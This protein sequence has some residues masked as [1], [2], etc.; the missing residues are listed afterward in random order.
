[1][2]KMTFLA[3][4]ALTG[5]TTLAPA[6]AQ[7]FGN[8]TFRVSNGAAQDH[9]VATGVDAMSSCLQEGSGGAMKLRAFY[10]G[11]LGDDAQATQSVRSGSIDMV[12]AGADAL[13]GI[14][15]A[16]G[17]F[18]LPF[19]FSN[20]DEVDQV[21]T[22]PYANDLAEKMAGHQLVM[23]SIWENGFRH[24]TNSVRPIQSVADFEGLSIRVIQNPIYL[25]TF[26]TL[27]ANP[28][29]MSFGEVFTALETGAVDG[30][31]NPLPLIQ[32]Q[33][34]YEV[35]DYA[36]LTQH[37]YSPLPV[38][39]SESKWNGLN[40]DEQNLVRECAVAAR[41]PQVTRAREAVDEARAA[42]E[43]EGMEFTELSEEAM[44][45]L[46]ETVA[47]VYESSRDALSGDNI[48]RMM[49]Q[50]DSIRSGN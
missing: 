17:V 34:F 47:P 5:M 10:S 31:E 18:S 40:E 8:H 22:G 35:Q 24:A 11:Q 36:T 29:P 28:V 7:E 19:L 49:E 12:V 14:E 25:A 41:D 2:K 33:R 1:M 20:F 30:M 23:L 6:M 42:L 37:A 39:M 4:T 32:S 13:A 48:D 43:S 9:P 46:R 44:A 26:R 38:L 3:A 21:M 16:M 50:L 27:G 45:E 15:P